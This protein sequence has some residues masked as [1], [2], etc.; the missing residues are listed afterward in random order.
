MKITIAAKKYNDILKSHYQETEN[1]L[2]NLK[3]IFSDV[4]V[5]RN[6]LLFAAQQETLEFINSIQ[7]PQDIS[8]H[9]KEKMKY[10][11]YKRYNNQTKKKIFTKISF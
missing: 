11:H 8:V 10:R 1:K 3:I 2:N 5:E 7:N 9:I 4:S 6:K